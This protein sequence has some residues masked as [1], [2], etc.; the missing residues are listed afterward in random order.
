[1]GSGGEQPVIMVCGASRRWAA[2]QYRGLCWWNE[3]DNGGHLLG[4]EQ[5]TLFVDEVRSFFRMAR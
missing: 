1:M 2:T 5:P 3:L 4:V